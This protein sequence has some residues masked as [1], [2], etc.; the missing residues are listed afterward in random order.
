M[1]TRNGDLK[2][3]YYGTSITTLSL[4]FDD[5]TV[6]ENSCNVMVPPKNQSLYQK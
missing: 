1:P 6:S 5:E 4:M 2:Y 3:L